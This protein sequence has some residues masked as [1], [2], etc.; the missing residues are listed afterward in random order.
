MPPK[1]ALT[2]C[3]IFIL[4]L[5]YRAR[6]REQKF[7]LGLW[8]PLIW[9]LIIGSKP[10]STWFGLGGA[11]NTADDYLEGSPVDRAVF[12]VL[13]IAGLFVLSR[14]GV[15]WRETWAQNPWLFAFV[16][17][18]GIS[19]VWSDYPFVSF[20]RWIKDFGNI[21]MV[22]IVLTET[23]PV[24]A[25]KSLFSR[26]VYF[27]IP[28]SVLLVKYFP[29]L[30]R[31]YDRW[32]WLPSISGVTTTKNL[33]GMVVFVS[34]VFLAWML[35][36]VRDEKLRSGRSTDLL[37]LIILST[38]TL[39]LLSKCESSTATTCTIVT[40]I[41]F[42]AMNYQTMRR[43]LQYSCRLQLRTRGWLLLTSCGF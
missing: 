33:L 22:M 11:T 32:T 21:I 37:P 2:F 42:W 20:K 13:I 35:F 28:V 12:F 23:D 30:G 8:V 26:C 34:A 18:C 9:I 10:I 25:T 38:M 4:W 1:V 43:K 5:F 41:I 39:W 29:E 40:V 24:A 31:Y 15:R 36:T 3:V 7:S 14:R 6:K 16:L 19:V 27:L 17:Y